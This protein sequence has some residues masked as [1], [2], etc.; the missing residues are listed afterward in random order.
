M[1]GAVLKLKPFILF[2]KWSYIADKIQLNTSSYNK[3][4][5]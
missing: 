2:P 5:N 3:F 4:R 1:K